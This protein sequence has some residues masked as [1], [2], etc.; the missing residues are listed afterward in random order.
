MLN[1]FSTKMHSA[2]S[3]FPVV[4][5]ALSVESSS[6]LGTLPNSSKSLLSHRS[7]KIRKGVG[8]VDAIHQQTISKC[9]TVQQS[10]WFPYNWSTFRRWMDWSQISLENRHHPNATLAPI[11]GSL[12]AAF[13]HG[14]YHTL[15]WYIN[16]HGESCCRVQNEISFHRFR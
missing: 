14:L 5:R 11:S 4:L 13:L 9:R 6:T 12:P 8:L 1:I 15:R 7:N 3:C 10:W 16:S 2:Y